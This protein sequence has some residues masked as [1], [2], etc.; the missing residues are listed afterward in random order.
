MEPL[1][2]WIDLET[3]GLDPRADRILEIAHGIAKLSDPFRLQCKASWVLHDEG[4]YSDFIREMHT[5]NGLI[6]ECAKS[7]TKLAALEKTLLSFI[8]ETSNYDQKTVVAGASAHF[9]LSFIRVHMP[10]LAAR[11]SHRVYDTSAIK[12]FCR[13]L[14]MGK[15]PRAEAH[16]AMPDVEECVS[17]A[18]A[19]A[20]WLK[21]KPA[22][23]W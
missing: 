2:L 1:L 6:A 23:V 16:R 10:T 4:P 17:Q 8:P 15:L 19:C 3:S 21:C 20:V 11:L 22:G 5:K 14:G 7:S 13:S 9:D 12:L 18:L